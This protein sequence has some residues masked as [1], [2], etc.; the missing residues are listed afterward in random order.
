MVGPVREQCGVADYT[1]YVVDALRRY[2]EVPTVQEP[3]AA[4][5]SLNSVD[6]VHIQHQYFLF[7]GV[8]PWKN[9]FGRFAA[10]LRRPAVMTV[11]EL[12]RPQG[13]APRRVAIGA[14]NRAQFLHPRIRRLIVHTELDRRH[15]VELGVP[16]PCIA[17]VRHAVPSLPSLPDRATA[18]EMLGLQGRFV[19]A[20][21]GFL[22][23]KKGHKL[24]VEAV[25]T[26]PEEVVLLLAGGPHPDDRTGYAEEL[27]G[28]IRREGM[29]SR[30][31]TTGYMQM[32]A[33]L[34]SLSAADLVLA[35][36]HETS[37]SG[38]LALALA[39]GKPVLASDI[40]PHQEILAEAAGTLATFAAG[41]P[42]DL[43][44]EIERL[45]GD[46]RELGALAE[47]AA[48]Y[49]AAHTYDRAARETVD[50]YRS[51]LSEVTG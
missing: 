12:V 10:A 25:R 41:D 34:E 8:A 51:V 27:A 46:P 3:A 31:I 13:S 20:V 11:H 2:V 37:G 50:V 47:S 26:L 24:A 42:A 44:R 16:P 35:P 23:R 5:E 21:L 32:P 38:S 39:A 45:R 14:T 6:L 15:L 1:A 43:A 36:F 9:R 19:V 30:V 49:A 33:L 40:P 29:N 48:R 22:S 28:F 18:R 7:G 17:L 4:R